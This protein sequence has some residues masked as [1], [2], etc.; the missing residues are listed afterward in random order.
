MDLSSA[1]SLAEYPQHARLVAPHSDRGTVESRE[2]VDELSTP[3][4]GVEPVRPFGQ[5]RKPKTDCEPVQ[6]EIR[7]VVIQ[8]GSLSR[9]IAA[10]ACLEEGLGDENQMPDWAFT[11][12]NRSRSPV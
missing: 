9:G 7:R 10:E 8:H 5:H 2:F 1:Q 3:Q 4:F 12:R 6:Y 11:A